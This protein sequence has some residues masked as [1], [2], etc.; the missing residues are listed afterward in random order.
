[1]STEERGRAIVAER[2]G[3]FCEASIPG[4]CLGRADSMHHR[5]KAGRLW[6]ASNLLHLCG[7]GTTGCHGHIEA[8]PAWANEE[9]LWLMAGEESDQT[10]AHMRWGPMRGWFIL[11]DE[12]MLAIV[13]ELEPVAGHT[14]ASEWLSARSWGSGT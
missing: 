3:G 8:N 7:S 1:M 9:G 10:A 5:V 2:S 14:T 11:D 4:V 13:S 12:G 6:T